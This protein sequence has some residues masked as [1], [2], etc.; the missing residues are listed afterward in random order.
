[1]LLEGVSVTSAVSIATICN[2]LDSAI[3]FVKHFL[4]LIC[5]NKKPIRRSFFTK[6]C[7]RVRKPFYKQNFSYSST[8]AYLRYA[9]LNFEDIF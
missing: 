4:G 9:F 1:M 5:A 2:Y 3:E 7:H 8:F 6:I